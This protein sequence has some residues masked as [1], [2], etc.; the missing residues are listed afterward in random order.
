MRARSS[1][2][3]FLFGALSLAAWAQQY[4]VYRP[5]LE[6][7]IRT[8]QMD[9]HS[10]DNHFSKGLD[11][12]LSDTRGR[13]TDVTFFITTEFAFEWSLIESRH[14]FMLYDR[15]GNSSDV[16]AL[17]LRLENYVFQVHYPTENRIKP[18]FG[19][20]ANRSTVQTYFTAGGWLYGLDFSGR[21]SQ[22]GWVAQAGVDFLL[23]WNIVFNID[24]KYVRNDALLQSVR[25]SGPSRGQTYDYDI[26]LNPTFIGF[27][28]GLRW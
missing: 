21:G 19:L 23:R 9:F 12:G 2:L 24:C 17:Q 6:V 25:T 20:G 1:L 7:K 10:K 8:Y 27:G 11:W 22:W 14:D 5:W 18:Y 15:W 28:V 13:D 4:G 26:S 3:A 16:G